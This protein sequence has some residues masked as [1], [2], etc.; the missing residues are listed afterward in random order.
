MLSLPAFHL[1]SKPLS[2]Q[3]SSRGLGGTMAEEVDALR[4][5]V[6]VFLKHALHSM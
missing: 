2:S 3:G 5:K 1:Q 4:T 6:A